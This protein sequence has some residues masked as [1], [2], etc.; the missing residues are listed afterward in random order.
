MPPGTTDDLVKLN[1]NRM[2]AAKHG[3]FVANRLDLSNNKPTQKNGV[4]VCY[5]GIT[6]HPLLG[7]RRVY[8]VLTTAPTQHW[9]AG[10][11]TYAANTTQTS[12]CWRTAVNMNCT[13][14]TGLATTYT[15]T[16][17]RE[18]TT[19]CF[20]R[21]GSEYASFASLKSSDVDYVALARIQNVM[22]ETPMFHPSSSNANGKFAKLAKSMWKKASPV[23]RPLIG[24][25]GA[26]LKSVAPGPAAE[27]FD[28]AKDIYKSVRAA[29]KDDPAGLLDALPEPTKRKIKQAAKQGAVKALTGGSKNKKAEKKKQK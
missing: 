3:T 15:A 26:V 2:A 22:D 27:A 4:N 20:V 6:D 9:S 5:E 13:I 11:Y 10:S 21:P 23:V 25:A 19:Q 1:N 29:N 7:G 8:L 18:I 14:L 12:P 16:I 24:T 28:I 17:S